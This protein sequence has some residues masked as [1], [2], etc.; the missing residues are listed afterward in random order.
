MCVHLSLE[1]SQGVAAQIKAYYEVGLLAMERNMRKDLIQLQQQ[2]HL[3]L[4]QQ[5][6]HVIERRSTPGFASPRNSTPSLPFGANSINIQNQVVD[7]REG[8][9]SR[10]MQNSPVPLSVGV[11]TPQ[12]NLPEPIAEEPVGE[13]RKEGEVD[14]IQQ[15][16]E[17]NGTEE[18]VAREE[19][20]ME[21]DE[22]PPDT[23]EPI[24]NL[25]FPLDENMEE[26]PGMPEHMNVDL[27]VDE[28]PDASKEIK[29]ETE[30]D[31]IKEPA[32][33]VEEEEEEVDDGIPRPK[34][35]TVTT[36]GGYDLNALYTLSRITR[37]QKEFYCKI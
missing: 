2:H 3:N 35:R 11:V 10:Q 25:G 36:T 37:V 7:R 28:V 17:E 23:E 20:T 14:H 8:V 30:V 12:P 29:V 21:Q 27:G 24:G 6:Q 9:I 32:V 15:D 33:L 26:A 5:Q 4:V 13:K 19:A 34:M 18:E 16:P 22:V 1:P 31:A